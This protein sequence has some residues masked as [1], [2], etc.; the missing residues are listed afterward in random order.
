MT[1]IEKLWRCIYCGLTSKQTNYASVLGRPG[2]YKCAVRH[3]NCVLR[4][5]KP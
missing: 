3:G 1:A 4:Q 2:P 5:A